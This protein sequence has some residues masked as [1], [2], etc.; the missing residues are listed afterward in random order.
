MSSPFT[1]KA[2]AEHAVAWVLGVE[3][4]RRNPT[5]QDIRTVAHTLSAMLETTILPDYVEALWAAMDE[6]D[7]ARESRAADRDAQVAEWEEHVVDATHDLLACE[8][9]RYGTCLH[10]TRH[11]RRA[12]A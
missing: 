3:R 2:T 4:D 8:W 9:E 5:T 1:D 11:V 10:T 12:A 7:G 6:L